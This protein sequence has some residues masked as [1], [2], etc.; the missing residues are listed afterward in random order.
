MDK[1]DFLP[2]ETTIS[3]KKSSKQMFSTQFAYLL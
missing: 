2:L 3:S 1:L